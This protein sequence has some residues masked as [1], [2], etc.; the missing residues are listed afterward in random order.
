LI[1]KVFNE[2]FRQYEGLH[3]GILVASNINNTGNDDKIFH[4]LEEIEGLIHTEF[5]SDDMDKKKLPAGKPKA[6]LI[7]TW[8]AAYRDFGVEPHEYHTVLE[9]LLK[10]VLKGHKLPRINKLVDCCNFLSLKYMIP[11]SATDMDKIEGDIFLGKAVGE[12]DFTN[13]G[14]GMVEKPE[15]GE[16]IYSDAAK[17]LYRRWNWLENEHV[18]VTENTQNAVVFVDG[19]PPFDKEQVENVLKE[20][21]K[22]IQMFC[23]GSIQ[24]GIAT[25]THNVVKI[26]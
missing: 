17:V 25:T 6:K 22:L 4:L 20:A 8:R 12:E 1:F 10:T 11:V 5:S 13:P 2:L 7:S 23:S 3:V 26:S 15:Q 18:Q 16:V 14:T 24:T 9:G 19:L 21:K